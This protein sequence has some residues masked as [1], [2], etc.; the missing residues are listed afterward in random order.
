MKVGDMYGDGKYLK[1]EH[2]L[3]PDGKKYHRLDVTVAKWEIVKYEA[4]DG[5]P[6]RSQV[7]IHFVGKD[8][9]LGLNKTNW[10]ALVNAC[11]I[12]ETPD[13]DVE[14]ICKRFIGWGIRL[15]VDPAVQQMDGSTK[16]GIRISTEY[17]AIPPE[18][19]PD[20]AGLNVTGPSPESEPDAAS[21]EDVK[22]IPF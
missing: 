6:E 20:A 4:K 13:S 2:L 3:K 7:A 9:I 17:D 18:D 1:A 19:N 5:K 12:T 16:P 11:G 22:D 15:Y 14:D 8:R 21:D 10:K